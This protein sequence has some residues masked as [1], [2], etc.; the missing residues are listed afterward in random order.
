MSA[1]LSLG[2]VSTEGK[3]LMDMSLISNNCIFIIFRIGWRTPHFLSVI[4]KNEVIE[5]V[6]IPRFIKIIEEKHC[7][8]FFFLTCIT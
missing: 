5:F 8:F 4:R 6:L 1:I 2:G 3:Y 7:Y